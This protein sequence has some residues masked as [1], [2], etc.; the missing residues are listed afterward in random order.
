MSET[1]TLPPQVVVPPPTAA[2]LPLQQSSF[3]NTFG[4]KETPAAPT[5]QPAAPAAVSPETPVVTPPVEATPPNPYLDIIKPPAAPSAWSDEVKAAFKARGIEDIDAVL[6]E[7]K[8]L[9]EQIE[10]QKKGLEAANSVLAR[11]SELDDFNKEIIR[12]AREGKNVREWL[13]TQPNIDLS[14]PANKQNKVDLIK[15]EFPQAISAEDEATLKDPDAD[16]DEVAQINKRIEG[17]LPLAS[18]KFEERRKAPLEERAQKEAQ[19][20][21]WNEKYMQGVAASVAALPESMKTLATPEVIQAH[22]EGKL[23]ESQFYEADGTPKPTSLADALKLRDFDKILKTTH[24]V[25]YAEG[26]E[27]SELK[28]AARLST[29]AGG[30]RELPTDGQPATETLAPQQSSFLKTFGA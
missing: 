21:A 5:E 26:M 18:V 24:D 17:W 13:A 2:P 22:A 30:R 28:A 23:F 8:T 14:K 12:Q 10:I 9:A 20:K 27:A 11:E 4:V 15:A 16:P 7:R 1:A 29:I 3:L 25:A 19:T 6:T